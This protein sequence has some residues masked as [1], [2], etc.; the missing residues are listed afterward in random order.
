[1]LHARLTRLLLRGR[2]PLRGCWLLARGGLL[3]VGGLLALL[4]GLP[5]GGLLRGGLLRCWP[6]VPLLPQVRRPPCCSP[7]VS[8][9]V[10]ACPH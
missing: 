8:C 7:T 5:R 10:R 1:M 2:R 4:G 6:Q 3:V 9:M